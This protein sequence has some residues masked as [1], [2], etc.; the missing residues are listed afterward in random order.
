MRR[1]RLCSNGQDK[2]LLRKAS[3]ETEVHDPHLEWT[4]PVSAGFLQDP[5]PAQFLAHIQ[6]PLCSP[7]T[8][9]PRV[10]VPS[11]P[12]LSLG[13]PSGARLTLRSVPHCFPVSASLS[14]WVSL[15]TES[16]LPGA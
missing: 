1:V 11:G 10:L 4:R 8:L 5:A 3:F 9:Q 13:S 16:A 14:S 7:L 2:L 15:L 12:K 6:D